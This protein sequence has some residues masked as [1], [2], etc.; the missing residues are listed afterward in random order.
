MHVRMLPYTNFLMGV[1][2]D[3]QAVDFSAYVRI[4]VRVHAPASQSAFHMPAFIDLARGIP[5]V[6]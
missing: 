2:R 6:I 3:V 1:L 5:N 4:I